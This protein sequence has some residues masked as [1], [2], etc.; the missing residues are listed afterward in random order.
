[1]KK[2]LTMGD[3]GL[4]TIKKAILIMKLSFL[5]TLTAT[6]HVSA[7]VNGQGKVS[8]KENQ[9]EISKILNSIEKQGTYRFLYN[10]RLNSIRK[11]ISI[12]VSDTEIK[13]VLN[14]MFMGTDL[15]YKVLDNDLI[16]VLS[17]LLAFQDIKV[18]GKITSVSGEALSGVTVSVKGTSTGTSTDN[19]GNFSITVPEK[20][21]LIISYIG[22][23]SQQIPV[24]SRSVIDVKL[25]TSNKIMDEVV[26]I[27]YGQA[28]KRDLTG[29]I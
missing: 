4:H 20:G 19:N 23:Q 16:V 18:T 7:N 8:L 24:N 11:K 28:S 9:V 12:D 3:Q 21:T 22:Y 2:N 27:G 26:V 10:S 29:S 15:T 1:M 5:L 6:L 25:E 13:D 14:K 17:S